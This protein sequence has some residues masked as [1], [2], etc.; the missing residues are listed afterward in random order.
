MMLL[1][2][3]RL[4]CVLA[5]FVLLITTTHAAPPICEELLEEMADC[6][7][8]TIVKCDDEPPICT[9][10]STQTFPRNCWKCKNKSSGN[11]NNN[12][13]SAPSKPVLTSGQAKAKCHLAR[14]EVPDCIEDVVIKCGNGPAQC[15]GR[16]ELTACQGDLMICET[17]QLQDYNVEGK[18]SAGAFRHNAVGSWT[19]LLLVSFWLTA[20]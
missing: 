17:T 2:W 8:P 4:I 18:S 10:E 15:G 12:R 3:H 11:N 13:L 19:L 20:G 9:A 14:A 7:L 1:R 5:L 6:T 16:A